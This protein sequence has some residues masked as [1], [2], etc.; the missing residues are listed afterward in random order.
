MKN[1]VNKHKYKTYI[2]ISSKTKTFYPKVDFVSAIYQV[3][4]SICETFCINKLLPNTFLKSGQSN[5]GLDSRQIIYKQSG[6]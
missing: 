2:Y 4:V 1:D 5:G 3:N 6:F